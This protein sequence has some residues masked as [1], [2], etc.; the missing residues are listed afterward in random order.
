M[1]I[2][3]NSITDPIGHIQ[4]W[5]NEAEKTESRDPNAMSLATVGH[6]MLPDI[7]TVL[8]KEIAPEGLYFYTNHNSA[9][10]KELSENPK[11]AICLYWKSL[12]RQVRVRG[13]VSPASKEKSDSYFATRHP[14][15]QAGAWASQ[16]SQPMESREAFE[17][18]VKDVLHKYKD[19]DAIPRPPNW[20]GYIIAP[21]SIEFWQE[22]EYRLHTRHVFTRNSED[23]SWDKTILYP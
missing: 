14:Q 7:R 9:K 6:D 20:G 2:G 3:M 22:G 12:N 16:Q 4:Q 11:A 13:N 18:G 1:N 5:L 10:A 19:K 17:K 8:L 23:S 15:S 21:L